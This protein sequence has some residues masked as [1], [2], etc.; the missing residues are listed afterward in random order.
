M[1]I[2]FE[3][4]RDTSLLEQYYRLREQCFRKE[5]A[6]P[7]FNGA[8]DEL[9]RQGQIVIARQGNR[10]IGG[11]RISPE[12]PYANQLKELQLHPA[13]CCIWERFVVDP[14]ARSIQLIRD[15]CTQLIRVSR[16]SGY[17]YALV[18]SSLRNARLYRQH[19][20]ALGIGFQIHR[21]APDCALGPFSGL[22]HYLSV[23]HLL[24]G[25]ELK[26]AA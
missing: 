16:N 9:D 20:S 17:H 8:E 3:L 19:H 6:L 10:C 18:L 25:Q 7:E 1:T 5:L 24:D 15:F 4:C 14:A 13:A 12:V 21:S 22:E 2:E 26:M 23:S 11:A